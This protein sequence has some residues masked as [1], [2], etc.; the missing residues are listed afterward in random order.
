MVKSEVKDDFHSKLVKELRWTIAIITTISAG[1]NWI[2]SPVNVLEKQNIAIQTRLDY[3]ENNHLR[4]MEIDIA[5]LFETQAEAQTQ[6]QKQFDM[7]AD[8][9]KLLRVLLK[10]KVSQSDLQSKNYAERV[11]EITS[12]KDYD[13]D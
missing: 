11:N 8:N 1:L 7:S 10:E 9:N 12:D 3:L 2:Q 13:L 5:R 6:M 4:H